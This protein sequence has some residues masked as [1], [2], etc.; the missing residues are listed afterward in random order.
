MTLEMADNNEVTII[1]ESRTLRALPLRPTENQLSV[2]KEWEEWLDAIEREFRY[3]RIYS[4]ADR[5]D[6]LIIYGGYDIARLEKTLPDN[7]PDRNLDVYQKVK[8]KLNDYFVLKRNKHY[9]RYMFLKS[10][11]EAGETIVANAT[12]LREKAHGCDFC[13][14][15]DD[16][17][18]EHPI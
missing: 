11:P 18:L 12:R 7:D 9:G 13:S 17:I 16:R 6:A 5:K 3:F 10:T 14:S 2:G 8:K 15:N 4:P 1:S